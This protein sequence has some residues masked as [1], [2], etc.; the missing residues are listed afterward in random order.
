MLETIEDLW[1]ILDTGI[2]LFTYLKDQEVNPDIFGGIV[3]VLDN[4]AEV[5]LKCGLEFFEIDPNI[6]IVIKRH[7][8]IFIATA[9]HK[10]NF[11]DLMVDLRM[12][13]AKFFSIFPI[14]VKE[15]WNGNRNYFSDFRDKI[16]NKELL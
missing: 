2:V 15:K 5:T 11:D 9:P 8:L 14:D 4:F 16:E 12:V 6:Y 1:I 3:T 10:T 7:H 13:V